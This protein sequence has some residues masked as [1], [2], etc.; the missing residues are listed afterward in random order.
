MPWRYGGATS[1]DV[2]GLSL[3]DRRGA[4]PLGLSA[5]CDRRA[6]VSQFK[7]FLRLLGAILEPLRL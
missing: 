7:A 2:P 6:S 4:G 3:R 1:T 5:G